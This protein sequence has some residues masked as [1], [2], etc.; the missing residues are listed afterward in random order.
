MLAGSREKSSSMDTA[1]AR[2]TA[3]IAITRRPITWWHWIGNRPATLSHT[4]DQT[5]HVFCNPEPSWAFWLRTKQGYLAEGM[6]LVREALAS[7]PALATTGADDVV[8][9]IIESI[10]L[11][12]FV[13]PSFYV[14][15]FD[16]ARNDFK[17]SARR[18]LGRA[19][20]FVFRRGLDDNDVTSSPWLQHLREKPSLLQRE[21]EP[22]P[23]PLFQLVQRILESSPTVTF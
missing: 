2:K 22:L 1:C 7:T 9:V 23:G 19:D 15:V 4:G 12:H 21:S 6:P 16:L 13:Q 17:D 20:V 14:T 11:L 5:A 18:M 10:S 8:N 3:R